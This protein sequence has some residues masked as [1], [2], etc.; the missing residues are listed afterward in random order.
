MCGVHGI[1]R[2]HPPV[3]HRGRRQSREVHARRLIRV[4]AP[5]VRPGRHRDRRPRPI[6]IGRRRIVISS[7][8]IL[9]VVRRIAKFGLISALSDAPVPVTFEDESLSTLGANGVSVVKV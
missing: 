3:I 4:L 5:D 2:D 1:D 6:R 9:E 7:I 8:H